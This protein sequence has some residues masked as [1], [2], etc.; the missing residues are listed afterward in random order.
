MRA[1]AEGLGLKEA[2]IAQTQYDHLRAGVALDDAQP[3][4][5]DEMKVAFVSALDVAVARRFAL[6]RLDHILDAGYLPGKGFADMM[7]AVEDEIAKG[8]RGD[9]EKKSELLNMRAFAARAELRRDEA[10]AHPAASF[11]SLSE[12]L[13]HPA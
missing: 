3:P 9:K 1:F 10:L 12:F 5:A 2:V 11:E 7:L 8:E 13:H 6:D 4:H